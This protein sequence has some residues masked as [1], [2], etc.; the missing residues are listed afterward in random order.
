MDLSPPRDG[1][2]AAAAAGPRAGATEPVDF[3]AVFEAAPDLYLLL[4]ADAPRFTIVGVNDEYLRATLTTREGP[5]GIIGRGL[6]EVFPDPPDDPDAT[7][8]RNLR[9][10]LER[11]IATRAPDTMA[12]QP[13]AIRRPDGSWEE[14][15]WSPLNTPVV[16]AATGQVTLLIHRVVDVT[17]AVR[18]AA[19]HDRLRTEY[20]DLE[21]FSR[22]LEDANAQLQEQQLELELANQQLQDQATEL[23]FQTEELEERARAAEQA[24]RALAES[25]MRHRLAVEA[26]QLGTW[27]WDLA[28]D[29]ATFDARVRE[30]FGFERDDAQPRLGILAERIH[31]DDRERVAAALAAAADPRGDGRYAAEYRVVRPDGT[32]RWATADGVMR[33]DGESAARRPVSLIGTAMDI[34][35]RKRAQAALVAS[36]HLLHTLADAIPTL[37]W[38]ARPDGYVDWYNARWY[39]HT[40]TTPE[41]M[42][43]WGWRSV[44]DATVLPEVLARWHAS[45]ASGEPFE[46]TFPLRAADGTSRRFLTR[47][48][49]LVDTAGH[50]VRWFGTNTD[51]EA[52]RAAREDAE[53]ANQAKTD[54]LAT[55]SHEL[56]TPLNAIAG[57][58]ELLE[59]GVHGAV[60]EAQHEAIAR[61]QRSQRHLLGLINDVLNFAKLEAG[62]VEYTV[63]DFDVCE[64]VDTLVPLVSPQLAAKSLGFDRDQCTPGCI[65]RADGEKLQQI[66][67]NLLSNA[68]KFTPR[69]GTIV[70]G[71][72]VR[73]DVVA[74]WV[75]DTG[76]GIAAEDQTRVFAPFVQID[77]RLNAP[78]EGTGLGLAI[79]RDLA[80]GVGGDLNVESTLGKGSTFTLTL[81]RSAARVNDG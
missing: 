54:F 34:T 72:A 29:A 10:S 32:E 9:A 53:R 76:I 21:A 22:A 45:I 44:I 77:R 78:G 50:V 24:A 68:I 73:D 4:R 63:A 65:V 70:L 52:E 33:F 11:A 13:Y 5:N 75:G 30:L 39:E 60:T 64:V 28:T 26:T 38:T 31:P 59:I 57:Y 46:M 69:G 81:P 25:E 41:Q 40:G 16:D 7:G 17:D 49:P 47:A 27:T 14:R 8:T 35:E 74:V 48:T 56:R 71:C 51:V 2:P 18:L 55:M 19:A 37:A 15:S 61:I 80:R 66:L 67:L 1:G 3:R 43:G 36:E 6:F 62:H 23:E 58:A 42:A 12:I 79:S 20:S